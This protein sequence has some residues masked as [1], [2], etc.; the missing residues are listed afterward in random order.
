MTTP[1][2]PR[3]GPC[4]RVQLKRVYDLPSAADGQRVL[5]DRLWPRGIARDAAA[6]N[7]WLPQVAPSPAL[8]R[9]FAHDPDRWAQF[10]TRY[11]AE[12]ALPNAQLTTLCGLLDSATITLLYGARDR[13]HNHAVVL[14]DVLQAM[15]RA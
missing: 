11:Q 1:T 14:A 15:R 4:G 13:L 10:R 12:L 3:P 9:W 7:L 5:V 6:I 8:R 2:P